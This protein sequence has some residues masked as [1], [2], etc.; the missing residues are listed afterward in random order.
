MGVPIPFIDKYNPEQ[1][2]ILCGVNPKINGKMK[3]KRLLITPK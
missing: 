2:E 1:F 3:F